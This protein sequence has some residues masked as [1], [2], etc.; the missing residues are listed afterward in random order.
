MIP[1]ARVN[2]TFFH[3]L[4]SEDSAYGIFQALH[5]LKRQRTLSPQDAPNINC[6]KLIADGF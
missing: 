6:Q 3:R 2:P 4:Q 1:P 5:V